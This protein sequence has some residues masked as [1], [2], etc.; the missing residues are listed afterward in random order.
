MDI[1]AGR[2]SMMFADFNLRPAACQ[3][4]HG[5]PFGNIPYRPEF[6][7]PGLADHG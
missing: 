7:L 5:A 2:I 6:A 1:I 4:G 3:S